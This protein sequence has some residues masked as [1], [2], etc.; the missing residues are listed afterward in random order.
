MHDEVIRIGTR[1][2]NTNVKFNASHN[3]YPN[4]IHSWAC[5]L[6]IIITNSV[7]LELMFHSYHCTKTIGFYQILLP[8][9]RAYNCLFICLSTKA[10]HLEI[11]W[12]PKEETAT[13]FL[14]RHKFCRC[15]NQIW[16]NIST[17]SVTNPTL[18]SKQN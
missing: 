9:Y 11:S 5:L 18:L 13:L 17:N 16:W 1:S 8:K 7:T 14:L 2:A 10:M 4:P 6:I 15:E 3:L 12:D